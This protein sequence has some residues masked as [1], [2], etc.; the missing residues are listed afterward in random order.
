MNR[1]LFYKLFFIIFLLTLVFPR[2][3]DAIEKNYKEILNIGENRRE[4][5]QLHK[6]ILTYEV[7]GPMTIEIICRRAVPKKEIKPWKFGYQFK[8]DEQPTVVVNHEKEN[9]SGLYSSQHPGHGYTK[10]GKHVVKIPAGYH[11]LKL[12][13]E[14]KTSPPMLIRII[15]K[16]ESK[17][18]Q[19]SRFLKP[20]GDYSLKKLI[21]SDKS[22]RYFELTFGVDLRYIV[23]GAGELKIISRLAF[24]DRMTGEE[25]YRIRVWEDDQVIGTYFFST[26]RSEV[27]GVEDNKMLV[28]GKWRS[29]LIPS[30][31]GAHNFRLELLEKDRTV[32]I[33]GL[34]YQ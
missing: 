12:E 6:N 8:V 7:T 3:I 2:S 23:D 19:N 22:F 16:T 21:I 33:K 13:P 9:S 29:C 32:Y 1:I 11:F 20:E 34:F 25:P 18:G 5:Y 26:E 15:T 24:D 27:T 17:S 4:Y 31:D 10:A 28:P 14:M 30:S